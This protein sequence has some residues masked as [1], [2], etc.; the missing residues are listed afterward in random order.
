[1]GGGR[2]SRRVRTGRA[3]CAAN[4]RSR[5]QSR[6]A[7]TMEHK[8]ARCRP[9]HFTT[10]FRANYLDTNDMRAS[11]SRVFCASLLLLASGGCY[12]LGLGSGLTAKHIADRLEQ[13]PIGT[14]Y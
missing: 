6:A 10:L 7:D 9:E 13:F 2:C 4:T 3:A 12:I 8:Y 5:R 14:S 11:Q 1:M